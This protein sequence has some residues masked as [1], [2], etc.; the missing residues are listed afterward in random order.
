MDLRNK[1]DNIINAHSMKA[2]QSSYDR[3][4]CVLAVLSTREAILQRL[5]LITLMPRIYSNV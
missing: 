3:D 4:T 1:V 2:Q 5:A